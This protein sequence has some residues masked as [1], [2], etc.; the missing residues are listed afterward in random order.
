MNPAMIVA[1]A[2]NG[3]MGK[4]LELPWR[5]PADLAYFKRETLGKVVVMGRKTWDSIGFPLP[6]RR[7]VVL[8][9]N[10]P[11]LPDGV[12]CYESLERALEVLE[13]EDVMIIGG[14]TIYEKALEIGVREIVLT[15]VLADVEGDVFFPEWNEDNWELFSEEFR[16]ADEKNAYDLKFCRYRP[17]G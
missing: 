4:G 15:R 5:L 14:A 12:E 3:V 7:N 17:K 2:N 10:A 6:K 1:Y 13:G 16:E 11:S 8:S 9:R